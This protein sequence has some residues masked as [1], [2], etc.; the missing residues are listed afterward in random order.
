MT[1]AH[2]LARAHERA[3]AENLYIRAV[4]NRP[5]YYTTRSR[6]EPGRRHS[7]VVIGDDIACSCPGF[8]YRRA[9]KHVE[10]LQNRLAREGRRFPPP[11][12]TAATNGRRRPGPGRQ[13][14]A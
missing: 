14:V 13:T 6:S 10:A 7:L 5:G 12:E 8:Y 4:A 1:T 3:H 2:L 11:G 9:C